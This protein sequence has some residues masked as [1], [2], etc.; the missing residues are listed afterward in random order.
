MD[1]SELNG[2]YGMPQEKAN[3]KLVNAYALLDLMDQTASLTRETPLS[4]LGLLVLM[5]TVVDQDFLILMEHAAREANWTNTANAAT[6]SW[7]HAVY[8]VELHYMLMLWVDAVRWCRDLITDWRLSLQLCKCIL[9]NRAVCDASWYLP[10][11]WVGIVCSWW[12]LLETTKSCCCCRKQWMPQ[13]CAARAALW[14]SAE[15]VMDM[16]QAA[17][18]LFRS[19][20]CQTR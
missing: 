6:T 8:V 1:L 7:M 11:K 18:Y 15:C 5:G 10:D 4:A 9:I 20:W 12:W 13:G 19:T 3:A 17:L 2:I 14:M 16:E